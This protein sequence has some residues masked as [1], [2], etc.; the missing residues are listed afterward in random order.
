MQLLYAVRMVGI[1]CSGQEIGVKKGSVLEEECL[2]MALQAWLGFREVVWGCRAERVAHDGKEQ[3][4][5]Q[6]VHTV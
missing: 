6:M 3:A 4:A 5:A 1:E 2:G